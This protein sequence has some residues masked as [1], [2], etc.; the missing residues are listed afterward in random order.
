[1]KIM[2]SYKF[3][4]FLLVFLV[5]CGFKNTRIAQEFKAVELQTLEGHSNYVTTIAFSP[6]G[7]YLASGSRDDTVKLWQLSRD[8]FTAV[9]TLEASLSTLPV[10]LSALTGTTS[11]REIGM[12]R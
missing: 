7:N 11:H 12:I 10:L 3:R 6:D 9:Q 4:I 5:S 8:K 2:Q 1:M